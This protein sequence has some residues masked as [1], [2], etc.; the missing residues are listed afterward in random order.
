MRPLLLILLLIASCI[1]INAQTT[2]VAILDFENISGIT[3]YDGLGKAMSSMLIS[4]IEANVSP[5]KLQLVERAQIQ[6]V[7]KEQYFQ[8]SGSV[9]KNTAVQAGKLL[10][11]NYL[12]IGDVYILNDELIINARL[13]NTET[14]DIVFS[15]KQEGKTV[16]WLTLK[17]NI[18]KDLATSLT[19]PFSVPTIPDKEI[20]MAT[21]TTFGNAIIAK[22]VGDTLLAGKL[23]E[24]VQEFSPEFKY[25][26]DLKAELDEI[27]EKLKVQSQKIEVLEKSGGRIINPQS[28]E[29]YVH[30]LKLNGFKEDDYIGLF[31][32]FT[33]RISYSDI[34]SISSG[35]I[36]YIVNSFDHNEIIEAYKKQIDF[37]NN[38]SKIEDDSVLINFCLPKALNF[39]D[40]LN[41]EY[42][43]IWM[44]DTINSIELETYSKLTNTTKNKL[45]SSISELDIE[46]YKYLQFLFSKKIIS[47]EFIKLQFE[48]SVFKYSYTMFLRELLKQ[49]HSAIDS[50]E[51]SLEQLNKEKAKNEHQPDLINSIRS[52]EGTIKEYSHNRLNLYWVEKFSVFY[53]VLPALCDFIANNSSHFNSLEFSG[54][55][56]NNN[57]LCLNDLNKKINF[58]DILDNQKLFVDYFQ[59]T[60]PINYKVHFVKC[61][62]KL[63]R[64]PSFY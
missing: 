36:C 41:N 12:L 63:M 55:L 7:L 43:L 42:K 34:E 1:A 64:G 35:P 10:G 13:T 28:F 30:N 47:G 25:L 56:M 52:I 20:P 24:T 39:I 40:A 61:K 17:T 14:G 37:L 31:K 15:K 18:A 58:K 51:L 19:Q 54:V 59:T 11:V 45:L 53:K 27:K 49:Q 44:V 26:D 57:D 2:R 16:G 23:V 50:L 29:D 32:K 48:H 46:C 9:N 3:K 4:D 62:P 5:K 21:I 6:K 22:D 60:Y 33:N 38:I 8:T